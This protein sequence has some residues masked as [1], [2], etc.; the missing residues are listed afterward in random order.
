MTGVPE[1]LGLTDERELLSFIPG[2]VP[3]YPMPRWVWTDEALISSVQLLRQ[4]HD[5]TVGCDRSGPWRSPVHQPVEVICHNDFAPYNLVYEHGLAVAIIDFDYASPG[6]RL[7]DLAYLAYRVAPLSTDNSDGFTVAARQERLSAM[8]R[9][10]G[11]N[12]TDTELGA[13]VVRRLL[14]LATFSEA[15]AE[16]LGTPELA[17]HAATY[18]KDAAALG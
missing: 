7:W 16:T 3:A 10:Y 1:V 6:P 18:R 12:A 2:E 11:T 14:E 5:S 9:V 15:M 8:L 4:F 17:E 13:T